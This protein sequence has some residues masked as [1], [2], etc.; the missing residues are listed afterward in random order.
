MREKRDRQEDRASRGHLP[1]HLSLLASVT[2]FGAKIR[3][4]RRRRAENNN[5]QQEASKTGAACVHSAMFC[6]IIRQQASVSVSNERLCLCLCCRVATPAENQTIT[7]N[8]PATGLPSST[9]LTRNHIFLPKVIP[10][11]SYRFRVFID[12]MF[13]RQRRMSFDNWRRSVDSKN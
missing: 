12:E 6:S 4:R 11:V 13:L 2:S 3:Q 5:P 1:A 10:L 9:N 8:Q 7:Q